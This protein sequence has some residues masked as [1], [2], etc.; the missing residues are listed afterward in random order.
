[1][2]VQVNDADRRRPDERLRRDSVVGDRRRAEPAHA[3]AAA[4]S[5]RPATSTRERLYRSTTRWRPSPTGRTSATR[6]PGAAAG[7]RRLRV[8]QLHVHA[9]ERR[10]GDRRRPRSARSPTPASATQLAIASFNV[11]NLDPTDPPAKFARL[12][13]HHRQQPQGAR[14]R[15]RRGDPGQRRPGHRRTARR[16]RPARWT[17]DRRDQGGRR[18][19]VPVPPDR[20]RSRHGRRRAR[21]QH[22]RRASSTAPTAGSRSSTG[23]AA[24]ATSTPTVVGTRQGAHLSC[25]PGRID[26]TNPA[27]DDSRKPLAGEFRWHDKPLFVVANHFNSKGG[28]D[29]LFGRFQPPSC[30]VGEPAP[31]AGGDRQRLRRR[32]LETANPRANVVVLGDLNDFDFSETLSI[33]EGDQLVNLM[34]TLPLERALL[35]RVRGQLAGRWTRSSSPSRCCRASPST[36]RCTSTP[37]SPT[38]RPTTT[39]RSRACGS[40]GPRRPSRRHRNDERPGEP[41]R[42]SAA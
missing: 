15:R 17:A 9:T 25:S 7:G 26:P 21:R 13:R 32:D 8:R 16:R 18:P 42:S 10:R 5:S 29:P 2:L 4:S 33:L 36:T 34:D 12:A 20:P 22:P 37:S 14:H 1:M 3:R 19:D 24:R 27:F 35:V 6:S 30:P 31:P 28:D 23:R 40:S 38:R 11:E 39:R 41:G